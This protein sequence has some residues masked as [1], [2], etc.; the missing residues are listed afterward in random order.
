MKEKEFMLGS[1]DLYIC[2][3]T[4][5]K[6]PDNATIETEANRFGYIQGGATLSYKAEYI[7]VKDDVG[8]INDQILKSEDVTFKSGV[9]HRNMD[10]VPML[11]ETARQ[12]PD[13]A[14]GTVTT[15]IGGVKNINGKVYILRFVH[16]SQVNPEYELRATMIGKNINGLELLMQSEKETVTDALFSASPLDD[17]GTLIYLTEKAPAASEVR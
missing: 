16:R 3:K 10:V 4:A 11:I 1:G 17:A 9:L 8:Y 5:E 13:A 14:E 7:N 6:I 2:E 15:K 12:E